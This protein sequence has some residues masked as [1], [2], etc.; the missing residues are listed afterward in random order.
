MAKAVWEGVVLAE[1]VQCVEV[2]GNQYFPPESVNRQYFRPSDATTVCPWKG[3]AHYY[4]IEVNGK[5]NPNAAWYYPEPKLA[6]S[7]IK[8][9]VA[10]WKGIKVEK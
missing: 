7:Q 4:D 6:A 5:K 10:F 1:S 8:D 3:I 2:E 9:R